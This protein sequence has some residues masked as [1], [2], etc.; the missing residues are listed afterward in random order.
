MIVNSLSWL[1]W[2][3]ALQIPITVLVPSYKWAP[4]TLYLGD[5]WFFGWVS[6]ALF[7]LALRRHQNKGAYPALPWKPMLVS[8]ALIL[9]SWAHGSIRPPIIH[10]LWTLTY[11]VPDSDSFQPGRELLIG[12]RFVCWFWGGLL[13][14]YW[15]KTASPDE[16]KLALK[17]IGKSLAVT[18]FIG[19]ISLMASY[20]HEAS[21]I[22]LGQIY[23]YDP[24]QFIWKARAHGVFGGP[25]EAG[26]VLGL[27]IPALLF[28]P[29]LSWIFRCICLAAIAGGMLAAQTLSPV[30]GILVAY[31]M[32]LVTHSKV[33]LK[34]LLPF[35][36]GL[37]TVLVA[38]WFFNPNWVIGKLSNF[39]YRF[40]AWSMYL[41]TLFSRW[42]HLLFG[43]GL[44]SYYVDNSYLYLFMRGGL[45]MLGATG[46]FTIKHLRIG[47]PDWNW[48]QRALILIT[49]ISGLTLDAFIIRPVVAVWVAAI[50]PLLSIRSPQ[51]L[52]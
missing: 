40:A 19:G 32:Y 2:A 14:S 27:S 10:K 23:H 9:V 30:A 50:I 20:T 4:R 46:Y 39:T 36:A 41:D 49:L 37:A 3:L 5:F 45:L 44:T 43:L 42:N 34:K 11:Q 15:F 47:W 29:G 13:A 16:T 33:S 6:A 52:E 1:P 25:I 48:Y 24:N 12:I 21:K 35:L 31:S 51:R 22:W 8:A 18:A 28:F 26:L 17:R 7:F 38:I